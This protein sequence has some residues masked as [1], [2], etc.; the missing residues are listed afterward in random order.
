MNGKLVNTTAERLAL[1]ESNRALAVEIAALPDDLK[2]Y[3]IVRLREIGRTDVAFSY[4]WGHIIN[5]LDCRFDP[6]DK[7]RYR[8][9][10]AKVEWVRKGLTEI[11]YMTER[12]GLV[13]ESWV[14]EV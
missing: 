9:K 5:R 11:E 10:V 12:F 14:K 13:R 2:S 3:V 6:G 1:I 4:R 8:G 7:I